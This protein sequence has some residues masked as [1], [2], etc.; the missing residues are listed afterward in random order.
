MT[1]EGSSFKAIADSLMISV[2]NLRS[3][4]RNIYDKLHIYYRSE[5][6]METN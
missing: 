3:D 2:D 1:V 5:N 6:S 4:F